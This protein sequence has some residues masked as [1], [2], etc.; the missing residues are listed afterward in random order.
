[1]QQVFFKLLP[2]EHGPFDVVLIDQ[3]LLTEKHFVLGGDILMQNIDFGQMIRRY[4]LRSIHFVLSGDGSLHNRLVFC[5]YFIEASFSI[6]AFAHCSR[7]EKIVDGEYAHHAQHQSFAFILQRKQQ[8]MRQPGRQWDFA[9]LFAICRDF[10][11]RL[12]SQT[13]DLSQQC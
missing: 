6:A 13:L 1:M 10:L 2:D 5:E 9:N 7:K 3:I 4:L 8:E 11:L 12:R